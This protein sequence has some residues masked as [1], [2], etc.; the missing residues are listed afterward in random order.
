LFRKNCC[1]QEEQRVIGEDDQTYGEET[2][3]AFTER[4]LGYRDKLFLDV[5]ALCLN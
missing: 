4:I 3:D 1:Y 5:K 2:S